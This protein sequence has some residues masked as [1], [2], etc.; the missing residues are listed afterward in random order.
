METRVDRRLVTAPTR[1]VR[2]LRFNWLFLTISSSEQEPSSLHGLLEATRNGRNFSAQILSLTA[3]AQVSLSLRARD[4]EFVT[5]PGPPKP[6][7][8]GRRCRRCSEMD[9]GWRGRR[10]EKGGVKPQGC[11][12]P[13][14][15]FINN[16]TKKRTL[17]SR[18]SNIAFSSPQNC[19]NGYL[20]GIII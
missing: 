18:I 19:D 4:T 11:A 6:T 16:A 9:G 1:G 10:G 17:R 2:D 5:L 15:V 3:Q 14:E 8:M 7:A 20:G 12:G 13:G